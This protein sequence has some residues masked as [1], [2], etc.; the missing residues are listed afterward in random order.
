M[1]NGFFI[2]SVYF[3]LK[4]D[5]S[6]EQLDLFLE[7]LESLTQIETVSH[8]YIGKPAG[9]NRPIIDRTYSYALILT[10]E[11]QDAHNRYQEHVVH[12]KFRQDCSS[13]WAHIKIYDCINS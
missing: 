8:G 13:F 7:G 12:E 4:N 2:H 1:K 10:F 5:L 9:T 11:N 3:W 6:A